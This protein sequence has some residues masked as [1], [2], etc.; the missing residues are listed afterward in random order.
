[1]ALISL[2]N[3]LVVGINSATYKN[4]DDENAT[5]I[6]LAEPIPPICHV[7]QLMRNGS[8]TR[9]RMLPLATGT[10]GDDLRPMVAKIF[11]G[12]E[13]FRPGDLITKIDGQGSVRSFPDLLDRLRGL[14]GTTL[15]TV[16]RNGREVHVKSPLLVKPDPLGVKAVGL[17]GL[18]I[19][20]PWRLDDQELN[21]EANL[22][23]DWVETSKEA[24]LTEV[25][26][27]DN[28]ASVDGRSFHQL[29]ALYAYL[30]TVPDGE[31]VDFI[32]Y[33]YSDAPEFFR[34]YRHVQLTK[35][36]LELISVRD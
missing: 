2:T 35:A 26:A 9:V 25:S 5:A 31:K 3:G 28:L 27:G 1:M 18:I 32:F 24:G 20:E 10:S 6:G 29:D 19:A 23:V 30:A 16:E 14:D 17:S 22:V 36:E 12:G 15:V 13:A 4:A 33:G 7:I 8:D 11:A 21:P 34:E